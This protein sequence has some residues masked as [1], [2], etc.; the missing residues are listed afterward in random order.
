MKKEDNK[1]V[2]KDKA[3]REVDHIYQKIVRQSIRAVLRNIFGIDQDFE[4]LEAKF[5]ELLSFETD[6]LLLVE[7]G[8]LIVHIELQAQNDPDMLA[9][10][11]LYAFIVKLKY[12]KLP[13]QYVIYVG[14]EPLRMEVSDIN[15]TKKIAMEVEYIQPRLDWD[16]R[17]FLSSQVPEEIIWAIFC[18]GMAPAELVK[19][20]FQRIDDLPLS[21]AEKNL[22]LRS[23]EYLT[24]NTALQPIVEAEMSIYGLEIDITKDRL[25]K[26]AHE[27]RTN[28]MARNTILGLQNE[29]RTK[30]EIIA[31]LTKFLELSPDEITQAFEGLDQ[32]QA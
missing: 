5:K 3:R 12:K 18:G 7:N 22:Y 9:R 32:A 21:K 17:Q 24:I 29:G 31:F 16:A 25:Y 14:E 15:P 19:A 30:A 13:I 8:D 27:K 28:E 6:T 20:I 2:G 23:L 10:M 4:F 26:V 1:S 11:G